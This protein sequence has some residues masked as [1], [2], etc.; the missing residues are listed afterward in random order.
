M[1]QEES[2]LQVF[3]S[4]TLRRLMLDNDTKHSSR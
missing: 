2:S 1:A 4:R 3:L